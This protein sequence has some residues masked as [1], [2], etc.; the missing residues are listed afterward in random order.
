MDTFK[1]YSEKYL[2]DYLL[3]GLKATALWLCTAMFVR[4]IH[5]MS[6]VALI[7][8]L[9]LGIVGLTKMWKL[10]SRHSNQIFLRPAYLAFLGVM[11]GWGI[12]TLDWN[13]LSV[14]LVA[15]LL[16]PI[17]L[18]IGLMICWLAFELRPIE[19]RTQ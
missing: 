3:L 2:G 11:C 5:I 18:F 9:I 17:N 4:K 13:V 14:G 8:V 10:T 16:I 1:G 19:K 15:I 12:T 6:D 7:G